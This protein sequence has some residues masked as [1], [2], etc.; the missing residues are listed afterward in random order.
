MG[1]LLARL[2]AAL[3]RVFV[4]TEIFQAGDLKLDFYRREV[5]IGTERIKL[6]ATEYDLLKVLATHAGAVRTHYQLVHE[7]WGTTQYQDVVHLL[8]VTVSN[9]A[10]EIGVRGWNR[11]SYRY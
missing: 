10:A 2:R 11:P 5:F 9:S 3:R 7:L 4:R 8:R 6:T 1:E